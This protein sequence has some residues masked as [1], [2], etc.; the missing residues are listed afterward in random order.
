MN[1][2]NVRIRESFLQEHIAQMNKEYSDM[3]EGN[4]D[5]NNGGAST[6]NSRKVSFKQR[7]NSKFRSMDMTSKSL[8]R[9]NK[10]VAVNA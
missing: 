7:A 6:S 8:N 10:E 5:D 4:Q 1:D 3:L 9:I 2:N